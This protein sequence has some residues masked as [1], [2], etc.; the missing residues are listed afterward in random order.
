MNKLQKH[1]ELRQAAFLKKK[2]A[3]ERTKTEYERN[4]GLVDDFWKENEK[5]ERKRGDGI[6]KDYEKKCKLLKWFLK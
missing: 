4:K 2:K 6:L 1:E 5:K 3:I